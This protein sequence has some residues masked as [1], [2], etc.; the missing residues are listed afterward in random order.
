MSDAENAYRDAFERL[1]KNMPI[2]VGRGLALSQ[3]LVA[4]EAGSDPSALKKARFPTLIGEIQSWIAIHGQTITTSKQDNA[5][6]QRQKNRSLRDTI[7]ELKI[8]RDVACSQL[9]EA[10]AKILELT[11]ELEKL[12]NSPLP[13]NVTRLR[14]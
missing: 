7:E 13:P 2:R 1:K 8:Q 11:L 14:Q 12:R 6:R 3:N 5:L 9:V 10:D 4:K